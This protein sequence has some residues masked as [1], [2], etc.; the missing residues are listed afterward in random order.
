[1]PKLVRS[2]RISDF[3][4]WLKRCG[5]WFFADGKFQC[6]IRLGWMQRLIV[7]LIEQLGHDLRDAG[8]YGRVDTAVL[9]LDPA[10]LPGKAP[11]SESAAS[12]LPRVIRPAR[13][14]PRRAPWS[15]WSGTLPNR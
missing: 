10:T 4:L 12:A 2:R 13:I 1:M 14:T 5:R 11:G 15:G 7:Q 9:G 3:R 6:E 8:F